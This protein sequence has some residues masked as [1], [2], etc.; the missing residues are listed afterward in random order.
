MSRTQQSK[1]Y[2]TSGKST[3]KLVRDKR[4]RPVRHRPDQRWHRHPGGE[5]RDRAD[6]RIEVK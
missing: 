2:R 1:R 4:T 6:Q 3:A 5:L